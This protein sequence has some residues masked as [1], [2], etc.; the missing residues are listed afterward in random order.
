MKTHLPVNWALPAAAAICIY[1]PWANAQD[2][3]PKTSSPQHKP[4]PFLS[5]GRLVVHV[6]AQPLR[7][8]EKNAIEITLKGPPIACLTF[9]QDSHSSDKDE[10][11]APVQRRQD[12]STYVEVVP[13][14][15]GKTE[16]GFTVAF[17]DDG[18]ETEVLQATVV[19]PKPPLKLE[20]GMMLNGKSMDYLTV[21]EQK[22]FWVMADFAGLSAPL[23][24]ATDDVQY[25]LIQA[26]KPVLHFDSSSGMFVAERIGDALLE[27][28]YAGTKQ[29][30]CVMVREHQGYT[31][32]NC[33]EL[34]EG[35]NG[36]LPPGP[37]ADAP[38]AD[39]HS[40]LP[41]TAGD[42]RTGRFLTDE[43]LEIPP[44]EHPLNVAEF[45][46]V[47][48]KIRG[49]KVA[50]VDCNH[51]CLPVNASTRFPE[52]LAFQEQQDGRVVVRIFPWEPGSVHY[53]FS[54]YFVDGGVAHKTLVADVG[55]GSKQPRGINLSCGSDSYGD[56]NMPEYL[57]VPKPGQPVFSQSHFWIDACY[58]G[59]KSLVLLP[60]NLV[61]YRVLSESNESVVTV[62]SS[63][64]RLTPL[65]PGT[66]LLQRE[67]HGL[68]TETCVIVLP[69]GDRP[70]DHKTDCGALRAQYG[71]PPE[72]PRMMNPH[73]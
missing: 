41:Y 7:L 62:D 67:F 14:V 61:T 56:P 68:K 18:F 6:P 38:A 22:K 17:A 66:A 24:I 45:N 16:I 23:S 64:G 51:N 10:G 15:L 65:H 71:L 37:D 54:V 36:V 60:P 8:G 44:P 26:K 72:L 73:Y 13:E 48:L 70:E 49:A 58:Q 53:D 69:P 21:G 50:R 46:A 5:E 43:R 52:T 33:D 39:W 35:G 47:T 2:A 4:E 20:V 9:I 31:P 42:I 55:F 34:R 1:L 29:T 63:T 19:A 28:S 3:P 25:R 27:T 12:G 57:S 59:I 30:T 40:R 32:G 11:C